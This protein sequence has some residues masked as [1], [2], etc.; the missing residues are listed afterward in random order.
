M[1]NL[2]TLEEVAQEGGV[3]MYIGGAKGK[4]R[5]K[6][7]KMLEVTVATGHSVQIG[8]IATGHS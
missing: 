4:S 1:L 2:K 3:Y 6:S 7:R 8:L 5:G